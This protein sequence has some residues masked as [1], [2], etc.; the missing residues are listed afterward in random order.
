MPAAT[1]PIYIEQGATYLLQARWK[2]SAGVLVNLTGYKGRMQ[3]RRRASSDEVLLSLTTENGGITLGGALGTV[4]VR[5]N[6]A[7]TALVTGKKAAYDLELE[8]ADGTV[9]RILQG[10]VEISPEV[11]R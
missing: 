10:S 5:G 8:S 2:D 3:V 11:T 9:T 6:A 7:L 1:Y 4:S